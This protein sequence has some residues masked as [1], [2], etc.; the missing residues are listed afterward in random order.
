[1]EILFNSEIEALY[2]VEQMYGVQR[3]GRFLIANLI[4][5]QALKLAVGLAQASFPAFDFQFFTE[6]K[7]PLPFPRHERE[8]SDTNIPRIYVACLSAFNFGVLHGLWIDATQEPK[9]IEDDIK[10][11]LSWS[12]DINNSVCFQEVSQKDEWAIHDYEN[13]EGFEIDE[14][15][16]LE[17]V[18]KL[19]QVL[20]NALDTKA[21]GAWLKYATSTI[22]NPDIDALAEEFSDCYCGHWESEKNF[23]LKSDEVK[24]MYNWSEFEKNFLFWSQHIDWNA[25]AKTVFGEGYYFVKAPEYGIYVF[26]I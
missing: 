2:I 8:C 23:L 17:Y 26:R 5:F 14:Y 18:S 16:R 4:D 10:W 11:M 3:E 12:P 20:D 13:F 25:I 9:E 15:E 21:M 19:A 7:C 6:L 1:M 24:Q 22:K